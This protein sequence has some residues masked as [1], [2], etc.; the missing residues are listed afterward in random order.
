MREPARYP[1]EGDATLWESFLAWAVILGVI[2]GAAGLYRL[3]EAIA[4]A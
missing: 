2:F 1:G 3:F 4:T